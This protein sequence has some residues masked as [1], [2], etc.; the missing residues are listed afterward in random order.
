M[1]VILI[2]SDDKHF[3]VDFEVAQLSTLIK[4]MVLDL[5]PDG[6]T[7]D[8]EAPVPNVKS[9]VLAKVLEWCEHHKDTTFPEDEDEEDR[10]ARA[11]DDWD[12]DFLKLDQQ[13]LQDIILAAN[14]L[15]I[16]PLLESGCK[17]VADAIRG[18]TSEELLV[19]FARVPATE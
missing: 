14:Y 18:K 8:F 6:L 1:S 16:K 15:N 4:N 3:P 7:E 13:Q 12:K 17:I 9:N 10:R 19:I 11:V 2:S 5:N